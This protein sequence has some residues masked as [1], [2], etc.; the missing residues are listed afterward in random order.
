MCGILG[1]SG[2]DLDSLTAANDLLA[3]RGPDDSGVLVDQNAG[4]GL[5]HRRLPIVDLSPLGHQ[6]MVD[7]DGAVVL[8]FNGE[9]YNFHELKADLEAQ[10]VS[11]RGHSDTE[12]LLNPYLAEGEAMLLRF[13]GIFAFAVWDSHKQALLH[14]VL[15]VRE[16]YVAALGGTESY[17][18]QA[19]Q[20]Q[21]AA[22]VPVGVFLSGGVQLTHSCS[23]L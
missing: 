12:V 6:S 13:S 21:M 17:L 1:D 14:L 22:D 16:L 20:R 18:R 5:G 19:V 7:A 11:F 8:V 15:E 2:S 10:V 23:Q 4:I 9:I 3:H